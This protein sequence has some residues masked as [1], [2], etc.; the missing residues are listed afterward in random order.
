MQPDFPTTRDDL[1]ALLE[2]IPRNALPLHIST[3]AVHDLIR[4]MQDES[5][6]LP[7]YTVELYMACGMIHASAL[8]LLK[9][10]SLAPGIIV[11]TD[12]LRWDPLLKCLLYRTSIGHP[13]GT[14]G[15]RRLDRVFRFLSFGDDFGDDWQPVDP[16][17]PMLP[18]GPGDGFRREPLPS[19]SHRRVS[20]EL[21][22]ILET[23]PVSPAD[24]AFAVASAAHA[25]TPAA[26]CLHLDDPALWH[27][28]RPLGDAPNPSSHADPAPPL[29]TAVDVNGRWR[30]VSRVTAQR[31]LF[32]LEGRARQAA[33]RALLVS[34]P[35]SNPAPDECYAWIDSHDMDDPS[36]DDHG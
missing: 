25:A 36:M 9:C 4:R 21:D 6:L 27:P 10:I 22:T 7:V 31:P 33:D 30:L 16:D 17:P 15:W 1:Q 20:L 29:W 13:D 18:V 35:H 8:P 26:H 34:L 28:G 2:R 32:T 19:T 3:E 24:P 11:E 5:V 12:R 14:C 23:V